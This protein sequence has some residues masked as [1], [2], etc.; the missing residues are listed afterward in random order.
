MDHPSREDLAAYAIGGLDPDEQRTVAD[1]AEDCEACVAELRHLAPAVGVLA[2]SVDPLI[3]PP[4]LRER[5]LA[6]VHEEAESGL[7]EPAPSPR[8]S[9]FGLRSLMLRPVTGLAVGALLVAGL[10]GYLISENGGSG[11]DAR[12]VAIPDPAGN[13][14]GELVID[15]G[16]ATLQMR[17]MPQLSQGAVYQ[18]WVADPSGEVTPS[19]TFLPDEDGSATAAI[20]EASDEV[21]RVMV[22]AEPG[23]NR[24]DP[25][26]PPI[27]DVR[28]G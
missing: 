25:T 17:G 26:L 3:P 8:R 15:D 18:V 22:T 4:E 14:E 24:T 16:N 2:E 13:A 11:G 9:R 23:P 1:H 6:I 5:L 10:G 19:A 20:P 7:P 27:L 28:T 21:D 12:T